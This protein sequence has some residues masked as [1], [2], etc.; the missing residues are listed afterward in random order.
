LSNL[1]AYL[2]RKYQWFYR[3][4]VYQPPHVY[5][6]YIKRKIVPNIKNIKLDGAEEKTEKEKKVEEVDESITMTDIRI[7]VVVNREDEG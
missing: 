2:K 4:A 3:P 5:S 6:P 1:F 7:E